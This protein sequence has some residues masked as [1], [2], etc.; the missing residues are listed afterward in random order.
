M[1][2]DTHLFTSPNALPL[3]LRTADAHGTTGMVS[4]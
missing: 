3:L 4:R 1:G 2:V